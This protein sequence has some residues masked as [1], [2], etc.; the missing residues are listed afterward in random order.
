MAQVS[1]S[2]AHMRVF[3]SSA[4]SKSKIQHCISDYQRRTGHKVLNATALGQGVVCLALHRA[5]VFRISAVKT[6]RALIQKE[7]MP[8][9]DF[10]GFDF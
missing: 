2:R 5:I 4:I 7:A 8:F 9:V 3:L 6:K 10:G 1:S